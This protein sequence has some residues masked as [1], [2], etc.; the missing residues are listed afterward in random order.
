MNNTTKFKYFLYARKSNESDD[1]Q[2]KSIEDQITEM[3]TFAKQKQIKIVDV[4][5]ES[6]S[7]KAP[8]QRPVFSDMVSRI[9]NGEA[10]GILTWKL[11]RLAR[12][13]VEGGQISWMLQQNLIRHIQT[14]GSQHF[15][16][17]NVLMMQLE[18]GM[19]N[20]YSRD[21]SE[22][23]KRSQRRKAERGWYPG[24]VPPVGYKF[25]R[26][27]K[28]SSD[29]PVILPDPIQFKLV[30]KVWDKLLK[31]ELSLSQITKHARDIGVLNRHG[32]PFTLSSIHRILTN[33]FYCGYFTWKD[34][35]DELK[36]FKG[37]H[38]PMITLAEFERGRALLTGRKTTAKKRV[39]D[40]PFKGC[41][42]CF[43]CGCSITAEHK[44]QIICTG[45]GTKFSGK[46]RQECP[47]CSLA[48]HEMNN[49]SIVD[50]TYY[51]C[52]KSKGPCSQKYINGKDLEKQVVKLLESIMIP[53]CF[54]TWGIDQLKQHQSVELKEV[55]VII[56]NLKKREQQVVKRI[57]RLVNLRADGELNSTT[58]QQKRLESERLLRKIRIELA[59]THERAINWVNTAENY[60]ELGRRA[61]AI[62]ETGDP[63]KI[64]GMM[65]SIASNLTLR[66]KTLC[67]TVHKPLL[68]LQ[69]M[70]SD[71]RV[72]NDTFEPG[73]TIVK[74]GKNMDLDSGH[75]GM[76]PQSKTF[77]TD[78]IALKRSI[79]RNQRH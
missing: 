46:N 5:S 78:W 47:S 58:F 66:D 56:G 43:E 60:L 76:L 74:Q 71:G 77:R 35:L 30:K 79:I 14:Y 3:T 1:K 62:I 45:C 7:A 40:F 49:P 12:N 2:S 15:P 53:Q 68:I 67:F 72:E 50:K 48:V 55:E 21:L 70:L 44:Y 37:R 42:K 54:H 63:H 61:E 32:K 18:F 64:R 13:P 22:L 28:P 33:E 57:D 20:Q 69:Q 8:N 34:E 39:Y 23:V 31:D 17:D 65:K 36:Q 11:N 26:D 29:D 25:N 52:T 73:K 38:K 51:H 24:A 59:E 6:K 75:I 10:N 27:K 41:I 4:F 19:A 9:Y 16:H